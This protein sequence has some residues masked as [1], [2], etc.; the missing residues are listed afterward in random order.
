M[1]H[2]IFSVLAACSIA[3]CAFADEATAQYRLTGLFQPDRVADLRRQAGTLSTGDKDSPT[4]VRL[5]DVNYDTSVVTFAYDPASKLFKGADAEKVRE[6]ISNLVRGASKGAFDVFLLSTLK[7]GQ[8]QELRIAVAG[9]DCKGCV[10]GAYRAVAAI[11]GVERATVSFK[12]GRLTAWIDPARTN[13]E[14]LVAA[15]EKAH[16]D[17]IKPGATVTEKQPKQ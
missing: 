2:F 6:R 7:P 5:V 10:Y 13:L 14:A 8:Q 4:E 11:E 15:L 9:L 1:N 16:V 12:E 17:V 3:T